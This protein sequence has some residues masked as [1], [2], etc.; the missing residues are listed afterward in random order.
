MQQKDVAKIYA[1]MIGQTFGELTVIRFDKS[2]KMFACQCACG[3]ELWVMRQR[4][5]NG[6]VTRCRSCRDVL[7][8]K[9]SLRVDWRLIAHYPPA[10]RQALLHAYAQHLA[11]CVNCG[12]RATAFERFV[13]EFTAD[14]LAFAPV[15]EE[16]FDE[17]FAKATCQQ[18][19][20]YKRPVVAA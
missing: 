14:P 5:L 11:A 16:S 12:T 7:A 10:D 15:V 18:Y 1:E 19:P 8:Y 13:R 9:E 4:L 6:V 2:K 17:R 20:Q 3:A